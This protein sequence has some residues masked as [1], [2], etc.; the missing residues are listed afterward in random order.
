MSFAYSGVNTQ[1][2]KHVTGVLSHYLSVQNQKKSG[3]ESKI[4]QKYLLQRPLT[5]KYE[6]KDSNI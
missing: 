1:K 2:R 6:K 3:L 5:Y 4:K